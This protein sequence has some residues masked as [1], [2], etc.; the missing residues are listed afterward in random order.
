MNMPGFSAEASLFG[1]SNRYLG[2]API[3]S[4]KTCILPT[5]STKTV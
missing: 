1:I 5:I 4:K 3:E 2:E